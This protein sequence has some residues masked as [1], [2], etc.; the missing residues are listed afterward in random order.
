MFNEVTLVGTAI[1][2]NGGGGKCR[3]SAALCFTA[4]LPH[5]NTVSLALVMECSLFHETL[6]RG[7][8]SKPALLGT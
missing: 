1:G 7:L 3:Q 2:D 4:S 6:Q 8:T 5:L